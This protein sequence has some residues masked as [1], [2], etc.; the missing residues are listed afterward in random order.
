MGFTPMVRQYLEIKEQHPDAVLFFRLGDFY[1]MFFQD[2]HLASRELEITLT[3]REGGGEGR[4][5]MCGVPYHA[6]EGYIAKLIDKGHRVAVCEQVE[7]AGETKGIVRR[8][9]IRVITPGTVMDS[10]LLEA[11][12]NNYLVCIAPGDGG[13]GLAAADIST[14]VFM[15]TACIGTRGKLFLEEELARLKPAEVLLPEGREDLSVLGLPL[16]SPPVVSYLPEEA[17]ASEQ[18]ETLL[19][20][21]FGPSFPGA[22]PRSDLD[23]LIPAAAAL[24][25]YLQKTQKRDLGH[26]NRWRYYQPGRYMILD[27]ATRR[28]L[29]LT[30]SISDGSKRNTLL[31][32]L[33]QT[34]TAM[35]GRLLK[36]WI[37]QP[38]LD[39]QEIQ[40]RL[41]AVEELTEEVLL[42]HD[43]QETLKGIYDLERLIGRISFGNA[44]ARDLVALRKSLEHLPELKSLLIKCRG[45]LLRA[46][47]MRLD[48]LKEAGELLTAAIEDDPPLSV[49][50]G[51]L[52]R[53]GY[54]PE[55]DRLRSAGSEGK[56]ML[57]GL[58][59]RERERTGIRSLKVGYN[60]VFGYYIEVTKA[61]L[62]SVPEDFQR[63]Q[64]LANA[65]RFI[66]PELKEYEDAILGASERLVQLEY[67]LFNQVRESIAAMSSRI[68]TTAGVVARIDA[69][70]S[71]ANAAIA[72]NYTRP[73]I[74]DRG[75][76]EITD[77]RHPV[78]ENVLGAGCFVPNDTM[79]DQQEQRLML[80]T[81]PNMAGK[82]TYMRQ[83]ALMVLMA[84]MGSFVPAGMAETVIVDRIFTRVGAADDLAGGQ[85]TFMMEMNECHTIV[86]GATADSL[87]IMDEVGRGTS[88]YDGIS[89]ARALVE[90]L[91]RQVGA[92][93]LF[94]TH[95][96][97]LTDLEALP[98]IVNYNVLVEEQDEK[99][100][101]LRKVAPGK[102]NRSYGIHVAALAGLPEEIIRR[103]G[104]VLAELENS[105][106]ALGSGFSLYPMAVREDGVALLPEQEQQAPVEHPVLR[107]LRELEVMRL[108]PLEALNKLY[109]LQQL[110]LEE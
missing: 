46:L 95:Y 5:P 6:A 82:S 3:G 23:Y 104:E 53:A 103:A 101:F 27:A 88:T 24:L 73:V 75:R 69:L 71:L 1:E 12:S 67:H 87:V 36:N 19:T 64:T 10:Q 58:E 85:S 74:S 60:R 38:L 66:T 86:N 94:S 102:A 91:H 25:R 90:Y 41:A 106:A 108:T 16:S 40:A 33:D 77:G 65:E 50:D 83:V 78:L 35:G 72:G 42:R 17:F 61:N 37:E 31:Q 51:G 100:T 70:L 84:Q 55:V 14:G 43:L 44:N 92:K 20:G 39:R 96:H 48:L 30:R 76:L 47:G 49:R 56:G 57:A 4:I 81:G 32:V 80:I 93:T 52:I 105:K 22:C 98:G 45:S 97:E 7:E 9:V 110:I 29:E 8:E 54:D 109:Q 2:A 21:Q 89:I 99:I 15:V 26:L 62:G 11:K 63:K 68:Q 18:T 13:F 34:V 79:L 28:N 59:E 107:E